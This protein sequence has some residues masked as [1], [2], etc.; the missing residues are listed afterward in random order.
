MKKLWNLLLAACVAATA[1]DGAIVI[2]AT[3]MS[4]QQ[5]TKAAEALDENSFF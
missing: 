1:F 2:Q 3:T 4:A 5:E